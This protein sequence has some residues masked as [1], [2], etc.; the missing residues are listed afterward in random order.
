MAT[1]ATDTRNEQ[2]EPAMRKRN[3]ASGRPV[4][5]VD[6]RKDNNYRTGGLEKSN[7]KRQL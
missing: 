3:Q 6:P 5:N 2:S 7:Y 4:R 1:W